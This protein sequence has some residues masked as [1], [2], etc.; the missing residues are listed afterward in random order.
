MNYEVYNQI[1]MFININ[2]HFHHIFSDI[3]LE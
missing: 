1:I 3:S 2:I